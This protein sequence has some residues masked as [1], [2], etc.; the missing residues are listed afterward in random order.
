MKNLRSGSL[1]ALVFL[2]TCTAAGADGSDTERADLKTCID[3]AL[4]SKTTV[5]ENVQDVLASCDEQINAYLAILNHDQAA[6]TLKA[7]RG[8]IRESLDR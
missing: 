5:H 8:Y 3:D 7:I 4:S 6:R 2:L 1:L